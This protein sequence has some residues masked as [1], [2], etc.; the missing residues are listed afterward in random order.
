MIL[1]HFLMFGRAFLTL[2]LFHFKRLFR[3]ILNAF[4]Q[5]VLLYSFPGVWIHVIMSISVNMLLL[6]TLFL[7]LTRY[8]LFRFY[9]FQVN[10]LLVF[11]NH[12]MII[13]AVS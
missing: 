12:I 9:A 7:L 3:G 8:W 1:L 2:S 4:F 5:S 6:L 10:S 13:R 11:V